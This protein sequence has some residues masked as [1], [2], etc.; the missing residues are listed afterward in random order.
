MVVTAVVCLE[1]REV[2]DLEARSRV[3]TA[4]AGRTAVAVVVAAATL[5]SA[6]AAAARPRSASGR[7]C[8]S[9]PE[10]VVV[11][12]RV[13]ASGSAN[14]GEGDLESAAVRVTLPA[15]VTYAQ[16][17]AGRAIHRGTPGISQSPG[18]GQ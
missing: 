12:A 5:A 1:V 9:L 11:Q 6:T 2:P 3:G 13:S 4:E 7:R 15:Q 14:R 16:R 17:A 10:E 8:S 18:D